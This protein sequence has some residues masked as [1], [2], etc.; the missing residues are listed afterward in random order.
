MQLHYHPTGKEE[1]DQSTVGIYFVD[2]PVQEALKQPSTLVGSFWMAN[3]EMNIPAGEANYRRRTSYTLPRDVTLVGI[4]PHMHLLGKSMRAIATLPNDQKRTLIDVP[5]WNYNWQDEY[6][7]EHPFRLPKGTVIELEA[8]FDNSS[9]NPSNPSHPPKRVTWGEGTLDE[10]L[11]CFFLIT[12]EKSED[13]VHTIFD[14]MAHDA[15]QPRDEVA[16]G[17]K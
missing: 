1:T 12:A 11:F 15:K 13:V 14:A 5:R 7:Y 17:E 16:R 8:A 2:K 10:M 4:V 3:Y 9:D 6:Y